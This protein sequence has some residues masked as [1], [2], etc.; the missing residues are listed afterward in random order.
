MSKRR[1]G[2]HTEFGE[3]LVVTESVR[4]GESWRHNC[5][6]LLVSYSR[7]NGNSTQLVSPQLINGGIV[8][9]YQLQST[10]TYI[11]VPLCP[12]CKFVKSDKNRP[13][14]LELMQKEK[15]PEERSKQ[16]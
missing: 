3:W 4:E 6:E 8:P 14:L 2:R 15:Q 12:R 9:I 16:I 11:D 5:G 10:P 7:Q 1:C 13:D